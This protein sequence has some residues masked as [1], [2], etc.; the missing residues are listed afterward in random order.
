[1]SEELWATYSVKD[2]LQ[3]RALAADIMLFDRLVFPV[4]ED[5]HFPEQ[6]GPPNI[7]GPVEW[8]RNPDEWKRWQ[9]ENWDPDR[10]NRLLELLK[11]VVRKISW[12]KTHQEKWRAEAAKLAAQG[13]PDYSLVA[14]RTVQ[15][16]DLPA[17]VT[18]VAAVGPVYRTVEDMVREL[19]ISD[20]S[21]R[22]QLP[23][24]ALA[25]ALGW[26]FLVPHDDKLTDEELLKETVAFVTGDGDFQRDRRNF[27]DWQQRFLRNGATDVESVQRALE[28]MRE[29][30]E[31]SKKAA[32]RLRL[33]TITRNAFRFAPSALALSLAIAAIPG[34]IVVAAGGAF[35]SLGGMAIDQWF[36]KDAEQGQPAP[37]AFVHD[38]RRHFGWN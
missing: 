10:Q 36:L 6:S 16:R 29:L 26:E 2:H 23:G 20:A 19:G 18:G 17:Y 28:E 11:P 30:L 25:S 31:V 7:A 3:P 14:T 4:P 12:D 33:R 15:T 35:L 1:M 27:L 5:A 24:G 34:G 13:V 37:T 9:D 21:G 32:G 8:T 22:T 38:V